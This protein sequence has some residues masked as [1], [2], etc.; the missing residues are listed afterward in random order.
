[1][2]FIISS[3]LFILIY[4]G[5]LL[6]QTDSAQK[7][8]RPFSI[9]AFIEAY[10]GYDFNRPP[11]KTRPSF[12]YNHNRHNQPNIN[13]A[14]IKM[15]FLS[16]NIRSNLSLG[17][18]TYMTT[19]YESQPSIFKNIYEA[20]A[21]IKVSKN[22]NLWFD[23]GVFQS[24]IGFESAQSDQNFTLTRSI[25]AESTPYYETGIKFSYTS[26]N[27]KFLIT[28]LM[29]NGWQR[30]KRP[31]GFTKIS[32]GTQL[33]YKPNL[34]TTFNYSTFFGFDSPDSNLLF[35]NF[36]DFYTTFQI[37]KNVSLTS[38]LDIG[39]EKV[40]RDKRIYQSWLTPVL[41][42]KI[43]FTQTLSVAG[44]WEYFHDPNQIIIK[45]DNNNPFKANGFS[46]NM[47]Y[48]FMP[49][50]M[51]RVE[52]RLLKSKYEVFKLGS[53]YSDSYG[54]LTTSLSLSF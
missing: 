40:S 44:R 12:F 9:N 11:D 26:T 31:S 37:S 19:N 52:A 24:H 3:I 54:F 42:T 23:I 50:A 8:I 10:Y 25:G 2:K 5:A 14:L 38:G 36:H 1:M 15:D 33:Q 53:G 46:T 28:G 45:T 22:K 39:F 20:N 43:A 16:K 7:A 27:N 29:L 6:G 13:L 35:R 17:A 21:G 4:Q 32:Y 30:I 18:G 48:L 47:D 49:H 51:V 41:I 34:T